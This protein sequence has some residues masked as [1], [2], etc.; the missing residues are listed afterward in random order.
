MLHTAYNNHK[1]SLDLLAA[2]SCSLSAGVKCENL[3][4]APN[5]HS[6]TQQR[7]TVNPLIKA[8]GL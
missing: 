8:A 5:L 6:P 3:H 1:I 2:L 4:A 7:D